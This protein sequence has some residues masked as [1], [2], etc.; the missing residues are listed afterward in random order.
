MHPTIRDI[1]NKNHHEKGRAQGLR[2]AADA[3]ITLLA[4]NEWPQESR[5]VSNRDLRRLAADLRRRAED[6]EP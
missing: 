3:L 4:L 5:S 2:E 6:C 1:T